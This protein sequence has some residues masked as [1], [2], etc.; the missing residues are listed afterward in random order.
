MSEKRTLLETEINSVKENW[1]AKK[2]KYESA[3]T[4]EKSETEK[5]RKREEDEYAYNLKIIRKK[6]VYIYEEKKAKQ[7]KDLAEKQTAFEKEIKEREQAV[8]ENET[9]LRELRKKTD[10]F[11]KELEKAIAETVEKITDKLNTE[12]EFKIQL[13]QK[14]TE[15]E[16]KL[17][18]QIITDLQAKIEGLDNQISGLS[19]KADKAEA[20]AKDIVMKAIETSGN[21]QFVIE[22]SSKKEE[23][24]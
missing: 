1:K 19:N 23:K 8:A 2:E 21:K 7:E 9:E 14:E 17:K 6:E 24:E 15:G 13:T 22:R 20:N 4:E 5:L 18:G 10:L 12:F 11:P 3:L 16:L